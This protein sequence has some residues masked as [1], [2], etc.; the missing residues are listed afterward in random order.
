MQPNSRM[1]MRLEFLSFRDLLMVNFVLGAVLIIVIIGGAL[2][3]VTYLASSTYSYNCGAEGDHLGGPCAPLGVSLSVPNTTF[4]QNNLESPV[5]QLNQF[6]GVAVAPY[7]QLVGTFTLAFEL[8]LYGH[9]GDGSS[10]VFLWVKDSKEEF[11]CKVDL[12]FT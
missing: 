3:P 9:K 2:G 5:T 7:S 10:P 8:K 4:V 11:S 6:F 12:P 1:F